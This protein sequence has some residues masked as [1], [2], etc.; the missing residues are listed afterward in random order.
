MLVQL[1][2]SRRESELAIHLSPFDQSSKDWMMI[3]ESTGLVV[4]KTYTGLHVQPAPQ[5]DRA[6]ISCVGMTHTGMARTHARANS[7]PSTLRYTRTHALTLHLPSGI[8]ACTD[9]PL[10]TL[11]YARTHAL[12]LHLPSGIHARVHTGGIQTYSRT[13]H[14]QE[15]THTPL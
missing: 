15:R 9:S 13:H 14:M 6:L 5:T 11:R 3:D 1:L 7:P 2:D 8:H 12:T 4:N 10:S